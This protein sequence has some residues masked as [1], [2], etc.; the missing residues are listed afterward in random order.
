MAL[1]AQL[2]LSDVLASDALIV[3]GE[4]F[5]AN[6]HRINVLEAHREEHLAVTV[7]LL[8]HVR[9]AV[10][11]DEEKLLDPLEDQLLGLRRVYPFRQVI[12][13]VLL[14]HLPVLFSAQLSV[15]GTHARR[16]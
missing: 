2:E 7:Q 15:D 3:Q 1:Q 9:V 4:Q 12:E 5:G 16:V 14:E 13:Q 11:Q 10:F 8:E 6:R